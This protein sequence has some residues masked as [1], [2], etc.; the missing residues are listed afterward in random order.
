MTGRDQQP[1]I[2]GTGGPPIDGRYRSR[3]GRQQGIDTIRR[4]AEDRQHAAVHPQRSAV[5][6]FPR[7]VVERLSDGAPVVGAGSLHDR[8]G[9]VVGPEHLH[10][11]VVADHT[12]TADE[13]RRSIPDRNTGDVRPKADDAVL[14]QVLVTGTAPRLPQGRVDRKERLAVGP[15]P[16]DM[17][18]AAHPISVQVA[19]SRPA[20][21]LSA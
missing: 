15:Q 21:G 7:G 2:G 19:A 6:I 13:N 11:A 4:G 18:P 1:G 8:Q 12:V 16:S 10:P 20:P 17:H 9:A 3:T 14:V 5:D